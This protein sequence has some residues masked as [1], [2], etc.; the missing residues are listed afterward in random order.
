M[1]EVLAV[2]KLYPSSPEE[3]E[4]VRTSLSRLDLSP[5]RIE[6]VREEPLAF[7]MKVIVIGVRMPDEGGVLEKV[8]EALKNIE[9]VDVVETERVTLI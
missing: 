2:I 6:E 5:A 7:G 8:E 3:V 1:G 9:G 4:R